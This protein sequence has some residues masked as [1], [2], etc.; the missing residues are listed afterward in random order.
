MIKVRFEPDGKVVEINPGTT[1]YEALNKAGIPIRSDCGGRGMCMKCL[2]KIIEGK[3]EGE[4]VDGDYYL[5]CKTRL[6][7][8]SAVEIPEI[9]RTGEQRIL[10]EGITIELK[11]NPRIKKYFS[12]IPEPTLEDQRFDVDRIITEFSGIVQ[13]PKLNHNTI[14]N[15]PNTL[16]KSKYK[17]TGVFSEEELLDIEAG[18]TTSTTYGLAVDIGTTTVV[19]Y[20]MDLNTGEQIAVASKTNPQTSYGDD[21]ISRINLTITNKD[22]INI[23]HEAIIDCIN[24]IIKEL[25]LKTGV[26]KNHIYEAVFT[27]NTTMTHL[28]LKINPKFLALNPYVG[29]V[30]EEVSGR[31]E[32]I[33]LDINPNGIFRSMPNIGG[34]VGGDT[35]GVILASSLYREEKIRFAIDIGTN[36]ELVLGNNKRIFA[37]STAAGPAFEGARITFGMRATDGAIEKIEINNGGVTYK[38]IGDKPPVGLCGTGLIEAI[39]ELRKIGIIDY[40]GRILRPDELHSIH[41]ELK[42]RIIEHPKYGLCFIIAKEEESGRE[43]EILLTQ[44]DVRETQL[45]KGAIMAGFNILKKKLGLLDKDIDEILIAGAFGNY[46]DP[47]KARSI[48]L[49]PDFPNEKMRFIENAAGTGAKMVLLSEE[50]RRDAARI[51]GI[52]KHIELAISQDFYKEFSDAMYFPDI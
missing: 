13:K 14:R 9:S 33:G 38:T 28:F 10:T 3:Y 27:G 2:V 37:C 52:T 30:R 46:I 50:A 15:I 41:D 42:A 51:S 19:G 12:S 24:G 35:V 8:D 45:A 7:G 34:F 5:A 23:L 1:I 11:I 39:A 43:E 18:N 31:A 40:K 26:K 29:V 17:I 36:G 6:I 16:R 25:C 21:V 48:G 49:L 44:K 47:K 4:K 32:D 20:L 22:G